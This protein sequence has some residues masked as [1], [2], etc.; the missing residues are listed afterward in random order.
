MKRILA[1]AAASMLAS[2]A[3]AGPA[4][5]GDKL[6]KGGNAQMESGANTGMDA[7]SDT[8]APD[9]GS[10]TQSGMESDT[11]VDTGTTASTNAEAD[12]ETAISALSSGASASDIEAVTEASS[13]NIVRVG[14]EAEAEQTAKLDS[15]LEENQSQVEE[16]RNAIEENSTLKAELEAQDFDTSDVVA[17]ESDTDGTVTIYVR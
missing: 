1:I 17:A 10:D 5:A 14:G 12:I 15:A 3:F 6:D 2:T 11:G 9:M 16:L 13:V 8:T 7:G 4:L